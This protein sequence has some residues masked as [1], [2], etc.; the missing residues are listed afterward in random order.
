[1]MTEEMKQVLIAR[2][3][4]N[5]NRA[6]NTESYTEGHGLDFM[7]MC[8]AYDALT[9]PASPALKL[10][11]IKAAEEV[12]KCLYSGRALSAAINAAK[13]YEEEAK[14][15]NSPHTAQIEPICAT[16]G[17][18]W[19]KCSENLPHDVN[20]VITSNGLDIG[21]AWWDGERW[22]ERDPVAEGVT[23]WMPLPAAPEEG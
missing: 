17:A 3:D 23:H 14:R 11:D 21:Q 18:E 5:I 13:W 9:Q 6:K 7:L 2:C 8:I 1:M 4:E 19:V 22:F 10:P 12:F 15:L 16:G 20:Y